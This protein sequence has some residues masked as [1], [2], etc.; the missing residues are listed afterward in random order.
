MALAFGTGAEWRAYKFELVCGTP[1]TP[2]E[3][4][5]RRIPGLPHRQESFSVA[6]LH[7]SCRSSFVVQQIRWRSQLA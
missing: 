1:S 6:L 4:L 3:F 5:W 7:G 2:R